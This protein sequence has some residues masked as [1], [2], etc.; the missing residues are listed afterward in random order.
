MEY[1]GSPYCAVP[2]SVGNG[3]LSVGCPCHTLLGWAGKRATIDDHGCGGFR[4]D[5]RHIARVPEKRYKTHWAVMLV[6]SMDLGQISRS[7]AFTISGCM[8]SPVVTS[9]ASLSTGLPFCI[10]SSIMMERDLSRVKVVP[11]LLCSK[12]SKI[13]EPV[14]HRLYAHI[15]GSR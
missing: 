5:V 14:T 7:S 9:R 13:N 12:N 8:L 3:H 1:S 11:L 4:L 2:L 10:L 6:R 15:E